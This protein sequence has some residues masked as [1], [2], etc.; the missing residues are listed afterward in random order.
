MD[1][2]PIE[3]KL[4]FAVDPAAMQQTELAIANLRA[5]LTK[6][7]EGTD[8]IGASSKDASKQLEA[9]GDKLKE[10][11]K[12]SMD[13]MTGIQDFVSIVQ[14]PIQMLNTEITKFLAQPAASYYQLAGTREEI[15][16]EWKELNK[17]MAAADFQMGRA[18]AEAYLPILREI[19]EQKEKLADWMDRNPEILRAI[20]E[21][22]AITTGLLGF[23][24]AVSTTTK[25]VLAFGQTVTKLDAWVTKLNPAVGAAGSILG[26]AAAGVGV[27]QAFA[28]ERYTGVWDNEKDLGWN[29]RNIIF[30]PNPILG[31]NPIP[32]T[33]GQTGFEDIGKY[34]MLPMY[35]LWKGLDWLTGMDRAEEMMVKISGK[36]GLLENY[37]PTDPYAKNPEAKLEEDMLNDP[38]YHT[39]RKAYQQHLAAERTTYESHVKQMEEMQKRFLESRAQAEE[40][41]EYTREKQIQTRNKRLQDEEEE[42]IYQKE[43]RRAALEKQLTD[44][45]EQHIEQRAKMLERA[46]E[47]EQKSNEA[48]QKRMLD[49]RENHEERLLSLA[50]NRDALGIIR[51]N[52]AYEKQVRKANEAKAEED[53]VRAETN[54][55]TLKEFEE[56]YEKQREQRIKQAAESE[57]EQEK[58]RER[59]KKK[60]AEQFEAT[61]KEQEEQFKRQ[62]QKTDEAN[63]KALAQQEKLYQDMRLLND[64]RFN[65]Q[66]LDLGIAMDRETTLRRESLNLALKDFDT[67]WKAYLKVPSNGLYI[68]TEEIDW[69]KSKIETSL[70]SGS[71]NWRAYGE[72]G[73]ASYGRYILGDAG[74]EFVLTNATKTA[75]EEMKGGR[76]KQEDFINGF[77]KPTSLVISQNFT[78][79]GSMSDAEREWYRNTAYNEACNAILETIGG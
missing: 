28:G 43:K 30:G 69:N 60:E 16:R 59:R 12:F 51:E 77:G 37:S 3:T 40:Q 49:M 55:K 74:E 62:Q 19:V 53:K 71:G 41:Y 23:M 46:R 6:V 61:L 27:N 66:L 20:G 9:L 64:Q 54:A 75:L 65:E 26:G 4:R 70:T 18:A 38:L 76:L 73:Y 36:L 2:T 13:M 63:Q 1:N 68:P 78:F 31:F 48:F 7:A 25:I 5:E 24:A 52:E 29:I 67:F 17:E 56:T 47:A 22:G 14:S 21:I 45:E 72:G 44:M 15:G 8:K 11:Y 34:A 79:H 42:W 50:E 39:A 10:T 35:G 33:G 58:E 32:G 57:A